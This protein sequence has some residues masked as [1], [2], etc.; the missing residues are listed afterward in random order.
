MSKHK[1]EFMECLENFLEEF[2]QG[3]SIEV[4]ECLTRMAVRIGLISAP[5]TVQ[6]LALI[7][8]VIIDESISL[9]A[10]EIIKAAIKKKKLKEHSQGEL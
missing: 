7:Q 9:S 6:A 10:E 4:V 1:K 5:T 8:N 3:D 2:D